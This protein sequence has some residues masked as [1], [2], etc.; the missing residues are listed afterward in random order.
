VI[1]DNVTLTVE[2]EA[3]LHSIGSSQVHRTSANEL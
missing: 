1:T 3:A 2:A